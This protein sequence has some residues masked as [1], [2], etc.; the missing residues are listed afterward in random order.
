MKP[1]CPHAKP[2]KKKKPRA[3]WIVLVAWE[4]HFPARSQ[5]NLCL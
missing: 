3:V 5:E 2:K 4:P 1:M